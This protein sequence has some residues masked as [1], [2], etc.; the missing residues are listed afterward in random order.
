MK[1]H[2]TMASLLVAGLLLTGAVSAHATTIKCESKD[3]A[4][5]SC[6]ADTRDGVRLTR[7]I[8][9]DGCWQ[10]DTW[11]Y[12]SKRIW[13]NNGCRAE[14]EVG[15]E[16]SSGTSD[17]LAAAAIVGLAAAVAIASS[18]D[19]DHHDKKKKKYDDYD[20]YDNR[21]YDD[22]YYR[23]R[24]YQKSRY[25]YNGYGGDPRETF[26]CESKNN[27]RNQC[28]MPAHGHVEIFRKYSSSPCVYDRTWGVEGKRVWVDDGCRAEFAVY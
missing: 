20:G 18:Q 17:A 8:S 25:G 14:F 19:D 22:D 5:K 13:V 28:K 16:Q 23:D 24:D 12:D 21:Y 1:T 15:K 6:P 4:Y 2:R 7:Q 26:V 27:H 3:G 11:G 10:G 9:S